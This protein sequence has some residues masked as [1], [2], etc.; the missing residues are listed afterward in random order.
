MSD[1][2]ETYKNSSRKRV[3]KLKELGMVS[4]NTY[5]KKEVKEELISMQK[6]KGYKLIGDAI[7]DVLKNSRP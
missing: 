5:I 4:L 7:E 1:R 6:C 3:G 2:K